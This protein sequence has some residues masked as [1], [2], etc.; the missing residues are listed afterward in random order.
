MNLS[1]PALRLLLLAPVLL[2]SGCSWLDKLDKKDEPQPAE[3]TRIEDEV[4]LRQVW[5][6]NV[7][8]GQGEE[9][10]RL[11]PH[12]D[13]GKVFAASNDGTVQAVDAETGKTLWRQR[14]DYVIT[15]GVGFDNGRVL[16]G[17]ENSLVVA[18]DAEDGSELWAASV[19]SEV[20]SAP[21]ANGR[22]V[23][24]QTVDGNLTGL[25]AETGAQRWIYENSVPALSLRG[26][27]APLVLEGFVIAAMANGT[28][29]SVALD[30]GT[31]RWE[32]RVAIPT[33]RSEIDRLID[34][35]GDLVLN[36][37]GLVLAPSYQGYFAAIDAVTGQ[38]RWRNEE[39]SYVGANF[40]FGNLYLVDDEDLVKAYR[41]GQETSVWE[42]DAL[43]R[44]Q[45]SAP[46]GFS[47]Y[48]AVADFEGYVHL[49]SQ[50]DGR[51]VGRARVDR[52]G[53]RARMVNQGN[54]IFVLGNSG[55]LAALRVQ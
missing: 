18:F 54:T 31:L 26:T 3:L 19:S 1:R 38:T 55:K 33:G 28:V 10:N 4:R 37:A 6:V 32:E 8:D 14:S 7:G 48:V 42:N 22:F 15:G 41:A 36:D 34:I 2:L 30:N 21:A 13:N 51:I 43:I 44:R 45:L 17:T 20:L 5:S 12:Y 47:N 53:G 27:S 35:D 23:V 11:K 24:V 9:F 49:L 40:G 16:V 46:L 52:K 25:D 39:S 29:V 50:V